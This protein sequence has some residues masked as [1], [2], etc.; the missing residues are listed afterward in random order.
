MNKRF[1]EY[2]LILCEYHSGSGISFRLGVNDSK[3]RFL[4]Y[5]CHNAINEMVADHIEK[6]IGLEPL[7]Y[8]ENLQGHGPA[9][10][11]ATDS[12]LVDFV[13]LK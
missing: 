13:G 2:I 3:T 4:S 9:L 1:H 5:D 6:E 11:Y 8:V 7:C 10:V 12:K